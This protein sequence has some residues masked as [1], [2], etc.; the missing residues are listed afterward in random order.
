[1]ILGLA[2]ASV[3]RELSNKREQWRRNNHRDHHQ[4]FNQNHALT[5]LPSYMLTYNGPKPTR[6]GVATY[7]MASIFFMSWAVRFWI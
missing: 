2:D 7:V 6:M 1:M 4:D 3:E 5:N